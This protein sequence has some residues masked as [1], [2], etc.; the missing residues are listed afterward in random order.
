M[1]YDL[2]SE[3]GLYAPTAR[4]SSAKSN[5]HIQGDRIQK[6]GPD[7]YTHR[8]RDGHD[9]RWRSAGLENRRPGCPRCKDDGSGTAWNAVRVCSGR[10]ARLLS[11]HRLSRAEQAH[12]P[13]C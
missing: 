12:R 3:T 7:L 5:Y 6:A 4:S 1:K 2:E 10:A 9:L 11:L 13:A 8:P